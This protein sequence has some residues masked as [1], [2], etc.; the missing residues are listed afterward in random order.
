MDKFTITKVRKNEDGDIV[1]V[2]L[3]D[4]NSY[5][6]QDAITMVKNKQID[7]FNVGKSKKG[8]EFLR[9]NPDGDEN[10]NLESM[11]TY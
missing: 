4:G 3:N 7:G 8:K 6:I 9:G 11:S 1:E 5:P 10:N 2:M